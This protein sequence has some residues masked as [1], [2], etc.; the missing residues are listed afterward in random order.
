M[1]HSPSKFPESNIAEQSLYSPQPPPASANLEASLTT[2]LALVCDSTA[3]E[4]GET[5]IPQAT[6][7]ILELSSVWC[8][9]TN[10]EMEQVL[11]WKQFQVC[12]KAFTLR[13]GEGMPGRVWQFQQSEWIDNVSA[14]SEAYFLRNQIAKALNV[15]AA[16]GIPIVDNSQVVAVVA[17]FMSR[18]RPLDSALIHQTQT[19]ISQAF[20]TI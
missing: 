18:A 3:W 6:H 20:Q 8:V 19:S 4:Y 2:L 16:L 15:R 5:W 14:Q 12:S 17:F 11:S 1:N 9:D 10:L 13:P 7:P